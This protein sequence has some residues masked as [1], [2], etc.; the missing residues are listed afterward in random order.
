MFS[1]HIFLGLDFQ[2]LYPDVISVFDVEVCVSD[3]LKGW[4]CWTASQYVSTEAETPYHS[5]PRISKIPEAQVWSAM[6]LFSPFVR[7]CDHIKIN[8]GV[9]GDIQSCSMGISTLCDHFYF[10]Y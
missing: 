3:Q 1:R 6:Q 4:P 10:K 2:T 9:C 8:I 7:L 5:R